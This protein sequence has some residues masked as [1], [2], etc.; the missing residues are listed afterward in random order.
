M[1]TAAQFIKAARSEIGYTETPP[2][3]NCNKFAPEAHLKNCTY[4]CGA[5]TS[6]L[7]IREKVQGVPHG[8][9]TLST[10]ANM[11]AWQDAD[12]WV[13]PDD[14]QMGDVVF[15]HVSDRNGKSL[16]IPS[17]TEFARGSMINGRLPSV[18]GNTSSDEH[19]SQD[20]GGG[21]FDKTRQ[22]GV[23]IG[24]G[25]P[26]FDQPHQP[27][28]I[29]EEGDD[30]PRVMHF[31][32]AIFLV[33]YGDHH[34]GDKIVNGPWRKTFPNPSRMAQVIEGGGT[35]TDRTKATAQHPWG[36]A[37]EATNDDFLKVYAD[38]GGNEGA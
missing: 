22:R 3:S 27:S 33:G 24:A 21:V 20:N 17:H 5:Y 2:G 26:R 29:E 37:F 32:G 18:G 14:I 30:M 13:E 31:G 12:Q 10:R 4:W 35:I 9:L 36:D 11:K 16:W 23:V 8:A 7:L 6:A 28:P 25:R 38:I 15:E 1:T 34:E 19:G